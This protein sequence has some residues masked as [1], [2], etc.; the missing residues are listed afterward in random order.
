MAGTYQI[1]VAPEGKYLERKND[2]GEDENRS[3]MVV[4]LKSGSHEEEVCRVGFVRRNT[5]HPDV[6]FKEQ[7]AKS[8]EDA[9]AA[10]ALL[11]DQLAPTGDLL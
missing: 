9:R 8:L 7:I 11:N 4:K 5:K 3:A 6:S 1:V 2:D 10:V